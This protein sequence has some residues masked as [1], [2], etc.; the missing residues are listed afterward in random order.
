MGLQINNGSTDQPEEAQAK[1]GRRN[2]Q[3][4]RLREEQ[5]NED[6]ENFEGETYDE[7]GEE[8][9]DRGTGRA[10][11]A[12]SFRAKGGNRMGDGSPSSILQRSFQPGMQ[13]ASVDKLAK[14]LEETIKKNG[15]AV[16]RLASATRFRGV[17][18]RNLEEDVA[19]VLA[20]LEFTNDDGAHYVATRI[21]LVYLGEGNYPV[22]N[23]NDR[24]N[25]YRVQARAA[26]AAT[27]EYCD[28]VNG[29]I[30][31]MTN[32]T[33]TILPA[34][35]ETITPDFDAEDKEQVIRLM[36]STVSSIED[37]IDS[38]TTGDVFDAT[39]VVDE[40]YRLKIAPIISEDN[41]YTLTGQPIRA[42]IQI[43]WIVTSAPNNERGRREDRSGTEAEFTRTLGYIELDPIA[44]RRA[45][46]GKRDLD[47]EPSFTAV[48]VTTNATSTDP[49]AAST[50]EVAMLGQLGAYMSTA[51]NFWTN[52][53]QPSISADNKMRALGGLGYNI[54]SIGDYIKDIDSNATDRY[55]VEDLLDMIL[56]KPKDS[57]VPTPS[58]SSDLDPAND[59]SGN[60]AILLSAAQG[61]EE[62]N[63]LIIDACDNVTGGAFLEHWDDPTD[64][65]LEDSGALISIGYY[66]V[67]GV[68][69]DIRDFDT[70][71]LLNLLDGEMDYF[72]E[73]MST[74][75]AQNGDPLRLMK[76]REEMMSNFVG[77]KVTY[78]SYAVRVNWNP[79]FLE[80]LHDAA[81]DAGI[82]PT[83][84]GVTFEGNRRYSGNSARQVSRT[85]R[86]RRSDRGDRG[87]KSRRSRFGRR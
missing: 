4:R 3:D 38:V 37:V 66:M 72:W 79:D 24:G 50:L 40:G 6:Y 8:E 12:G 7:D 74:Y 82:Q 41:Q 56:T 65:I 47:D 45:R 39:Q 59:K 69:R 35:I 70:Q 54:A 61:D 64:T 10:N 42:D 81:S 1:R 76:E 18:A 44:Q 75:D 67:G 13:D 36:Q 68:K 34:G 29:L 43:P 15:P 85:A 73:I 51:N 17:S 28:K 77:T 11:R 16:E 33:V 80:A 84:E 31:E 57:N 53:F 23:F 46:F 52:V 71:A 49:S 5:R 86:G 63:Q 78:T 32:G 55:M 22:R 60:V 27:V 48:F 87:R 30:Q 9:D 83:I 58:F 26:D 20:T 19:C 14:L 25:K 21:I 62:A 2:R